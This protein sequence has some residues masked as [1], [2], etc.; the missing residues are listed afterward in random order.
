MEGLMLEMW[1]GSV[2]WGGGMG[3]LR[4]IYGACR[5]HI[6]VVDIAVIKRRKTYS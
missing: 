5:V 3:M 1:M 4:R 6:S 2:G